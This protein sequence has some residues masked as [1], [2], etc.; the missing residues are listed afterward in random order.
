MRMS[1]VLLLMTP[2]FGAGQD[3]T[4][5]AY[6]VTPVS[7][8][9]VILTYAFSDGELNFDPTLPITDASGTINM[10]VLTLYSSFSFFGRSANVNGSLPYAGGEIRGLLGGD[11]REVHRAG[12]SDVS[13]RFSTNLIGAPALTPAAYVKT[14]AAKATLGA[15]LKVV[16]PT[17]QYDPT[18]LINVG[19]NRWAFKPELGYT[20]RVRSVVVDAYAGLWLFTAN[21]NFFATDHESPGKTRTQDPITALEFHVSYDVK[22]RLWI[23]ADINYWYGGKTSV[24][25]VESTASLQAN[26]R[27]GVTGSLPLTRHQAIKVSYSDG[28]VIRIGGSFKIL[29]AGW[30]YSWL[31]LPLAKH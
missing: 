4:P 20:R 29:S 1:I 28:V 26:S 19:N 17:G 13:F 21:D 9:A 30:Q 6:T 27:F 18:R 15:S 12:T 31:G 25:G 10:G 5:R 8:N 23:S 11:A 16:L 22:P 14:P 7:S 3:L 2:A 24:N